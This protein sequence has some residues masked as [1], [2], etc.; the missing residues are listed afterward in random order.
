MT[1]VRIQMHRSHTYESHRI[2]YSQSLVIHNN[3]AFDNWLVT[4]IAK[5]SIANISRYVENEQ[6]RFCYDSVNTC[7]L[8]LSKAESTIDK[9]VFFSSL[10]Y[11]FTQRTGSLSSYFIHTQIIINNNI[12]KK[13][14][15][16]HSQ[17]DMITISFL[18][19]NFLKS[20]F[21]SPLKWTAAATTTWS[22]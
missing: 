20:V 12:N 7:V 21:I 17:S 16:A 6:K 10:I 22:C 11:P 13:I 15:L 8:S 14:S 4:R 1:I 19:R 9:L 3:R 18:E 2:Y 5:H